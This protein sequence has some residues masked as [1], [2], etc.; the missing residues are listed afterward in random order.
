MRKVTFGCANSLDNY[1]A[2]HDG[3]VDWLLW[4]DETGE[5]MKEFWP[6]IDTI[7]MGRKTWDVGRRE[8]AKMGK[9]A[10]NPYAGMKAYVFSR[11][12]EPGEADGVE[13]VSEDPV[14]FVRHLKEQDGMEI[15]VMGGGEL[16]RPLLEA[17]MIDEIGVNIQPVLLGSGVPLFH[18]MS[19]QLDLDRIDC[20]PMKNGCVYLLYRVRN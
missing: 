19:R 14:E 11:T 1:I 9:N 18:H 4:S 2:R 12:T 17:G 8:A 13:I 7:V 3:S 20:R 16:A 10:P 15:C 5:I 6:R